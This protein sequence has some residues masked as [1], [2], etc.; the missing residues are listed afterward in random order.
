MR[1]HAFPVGIADAPDPRYIRPEIL[2][3]ND[4]PAVCGYTGLFKL[5]TIRIRPSSDTDKDFV[6]GRFAGLSLRGVQNR[7]PSVLVCDLLNPGSG[8]DLHLSADLLRV[9]RGDLRVDRRQDPFQ[10]LDH[11]DLY[12]EP[13]VRRSDLHPDHAAADSSPS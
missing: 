7:F 13:A 2:I 11:D 10:R 12:P 5:Q 6:G 1:Q 4:R 8:M 9:L 3:H